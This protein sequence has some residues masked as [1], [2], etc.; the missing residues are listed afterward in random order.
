MPTEAELTAA[1][2]V[3]RSTVREALNRL[4]SERLIDIHH[5]GSKTVLDYREHAG[6]ELVPQLLERP[7]GQVDLEVVRSVVELREV[8]APDAARLCALR[9]TEA[10][11]EAVQRAAEAVDPSL[12]LDELVHHSLAL[13]RAVVRGSHNVAYQ[14]AFNSL[15]V[16]EAGDVGLL[17][18]LIAPELRAREACRVLAEAITRREPGSAS[19]AAA[20][21]V[22]KGSRPLFAALEAASGDT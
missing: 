10:E 16:T 6:L 11:A 14:L 13:W 9:R 1:L 5:G 15:R 12:S 21:L 17:R 3:S 8:M 19:I 2:G 20:E 22:A 7:D 18:Q 4:A